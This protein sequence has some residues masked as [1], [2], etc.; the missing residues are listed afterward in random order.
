[1]ST[2]THL[3]DSIAH[4]LKAWRERERAFAELTALDDR[5]LADLGVRRADI[6]FLVY[7]KAQHH[8]Q[9]ATAAIASQGFDPANSN[10]GL[11]AA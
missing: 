11:R 9:G 3:L 10:S 2:L 6:P 5:S 4:R 8:Q 1:M 7:C